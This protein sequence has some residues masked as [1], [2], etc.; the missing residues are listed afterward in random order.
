MQVT[1]STH[2]GDPPAVVPH[3]AAAVGAGLAPPEGSA[4]RA[5]WRGLLLAGLVFFLAPLAYALYTGHVWEDFF[6]TFRYSRNLA[7][8]NGL[9]FEPGER[10]HGFTSPINV[11]LPA[12]FDR[13]NESRSYE[14]PLRAFR[15]VS[16]AAFAAAGLLLVRLLGQES[17]PRD[18]APLVFALLLLLDFKAVAFSANGQ[19]T[20]F[21]LFFLALGFACIYRGPAESWR[22]L[23][24]SWAGLLWTRPDGFIYIAILGFASLAFGTAPGRKQL[25][26]LI[27]A[28]LLCAVLYLPWFL[29]AWFYYGTPVPHTVVA[30]AIGRPDAPTGVALVKRVLAGVVDVAALT[31][32]PIYANLGS[33]PAWVDGLCLALGVFAAVYWLIPSADRPGRMASFIYLLG[34][35]Y[36]SFY[37][38]TSYNG[39][40]FPWYLPPVNFFAL[41][42]LARA[43]A[44]LLTM[45]GSMKSVPFVPL[46]IQ[47]VLVAGL[48]IMF[49]SGCRQMRVQ[50][51]EIELGVRVP[52]GQWLAQN[53]APG[54]TVYSEA[55]GYFGFFSQRHMLD[56]PGLVS[57]RV[58]QA[59][60]SG[61]N[62][63]YSVLAAIRPDW[64][65]LRPWELRDASRVHALEKDYELV[66]DFQASPLLSNYASMPGFNYIQVDRAFVILRRKH[67]AEG[68]I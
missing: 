24:I 23:G 32:A 39:V 50:Q 5:S 48:A 35:F 37:V 29:T 6:I 22:L 20:A 51:Q 57:P 31:A 2:G 15:V 44:T 66:K 12:L 61:H 21:V 38:A 33:W 58:V 60:R 47:A 17:R 52:V 59:R 67:R 54:E 28:A 8:G 65:V 30:K 43:P 68:G 49:V 13:L 55:L 7:L 4:P 27:R 36:L 53:V 9:V 41:V 10:V 14:V 1:E 62:D 56:W 63:Y 3:A 42:V 25:P 19:E 40:P 11:L 46:L 34:C 18:A 26:A 45:I 16:A 64:L